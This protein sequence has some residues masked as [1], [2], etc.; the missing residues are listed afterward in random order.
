MEVDPIDLMLDGLWH[1]TD[2]AGASA[3]ASAGC[4]R[5]SSL[6]GKRVECYARHLGAVAIFDLRVRTFTDVEPRDVENQIINCRGFLGGLQGHA[7]GLNLSVSIDTVLRG[8][9][10]PNARLPE[11]VLAEDGTRYIP[12]HIPFFERWHVGD[13]DIAFV[14][15]VWL[16]SIPQRTRSLRAPHRPW[17]SGGC[18]ATLDEAVASAAGSEIP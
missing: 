18:F 1:F 5:A 4:I 14:D 16:W 8:P 7:F 9:S 6:S 17:E 12:N 11:V 10:V 2:T 13:I 3:I 15:R